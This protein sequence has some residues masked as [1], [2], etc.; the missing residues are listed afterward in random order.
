MINP[1]FHFLIFFVLV[2]GSLC[3]AQSSPPL[4]PQNLVAVVRTTPRLTTFG[5]IVEGT[6]ITISGLVIPDGAKTS[7]A[8]FGIEYRGY[9]DPGGELYV[10][11]DTSEVERSQK[12]SKK[13]GDIA[14]L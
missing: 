7:L 5:D 12:P 10:R 9:V 3:L 6:K 1:K 8:E 4:P 14:D 11:L 2:L 13:I